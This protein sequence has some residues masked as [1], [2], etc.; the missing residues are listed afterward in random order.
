MAISLRGVPAFDPKRGEIWWVDLDPTEGDEIQKWR[1]CVVVS[2]DAFRSLDVRL[3]MPL[4]SW[5]PMF[6]RLPY[7]TKIEAAGVN[8]LQ[9]DSSANALQMRC[10]STLR[11]DS[12]AGSIGILTAVQMEEII[13]SLAAVVEGNFS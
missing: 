3:V 6:A 12:K 8:G 13:I 4:T 7:H 9:K 1:P 10:V 5:Q 11:F 2:S